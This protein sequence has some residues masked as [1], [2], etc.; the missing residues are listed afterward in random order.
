MRYSCSVLLAVGAAACT[1]SP[2]NSGAQVARA[3]DPPRSTTVAASRRTA[4]T[5]AVA[6]V[7]P[8]VVTVQTEVVQRVQA[9]PFEAFFGGG[10]SSTRS[11]AGL[12]TGFI[13]RPDGIIVTNAHVVAGATTITVMLRDAT[14]WRAAR[15]PPR[16][17]T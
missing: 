6:K 14:S 4:I 8:A 11:S 10:G 15:A 9:D 13:I 16:I 2:S 17:S 5:D 7:A 1:G 3:S 12:G